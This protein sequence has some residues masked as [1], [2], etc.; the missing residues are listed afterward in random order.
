MRDA[1]G[2]IT[3]SLEAGNP[4][5]ATE[6]L[7]HVKSKLTDTKFFTSEPINITAEY[8]RSEKKIQEQRDLAQEG[9]KPEEVKQAM[10]K[11]ATMVKKDTLKK[12]T[13]FVSG[14]NAQEVPQDIYKSI[15]LKQATIRA[16][17]DG[18]NIS[19]CRVQPMSDIEI[20]AKEM[21]DGFLQESDFM[22]IQIGGES[23]QANS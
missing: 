10:T 23:F 18:L 5:K 11:T 13:T 14:F 17:V 3:K 16:E 15:L 6:I 2:G 1:L 20:Q 12:L 22:P 4:R 19:S 7:R 21:V 9:K 8:E